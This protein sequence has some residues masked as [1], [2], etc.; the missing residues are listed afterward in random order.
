MREV[1]SWFK[2]RN[3]SDIL[4]KVDSQILA[5]SIN[6]STEDITSIGLVVDDCKALLMAIDQCL[7]RFVYRLA[8]SVAHN[9]SS[10]SDLKEWVMSCPSFISDVI[11]HDLI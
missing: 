7:V 3:F 5:N 9:I 10:M 11:S 4:V 2:K 6:G 8:N 1:L